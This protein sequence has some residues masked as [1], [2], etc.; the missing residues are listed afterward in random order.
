MTG[1]GLPP[2]F[3]LVMFEDKTP[4]NTADEKKTGALKVKKQDAALQIL[5]QELQSTREYLQATIEEMETSNEELKSANEELQSVNEE[6]QSTNEELET[7]KEELQSTNEELATVNSELQIKVDEFAK[8]NDDMNNLLAATE[9]ASIFLDT[10]LYHQT[11]HPCRSEYNQFDS[12]GYRP[13][14]Q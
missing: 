12:N 9:I 14:V 13:V 11:V 2:G 4:V 1:K 6:L 10:N 5:E 8:A 7:S 3:M